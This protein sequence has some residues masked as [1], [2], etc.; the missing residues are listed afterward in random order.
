MKDE[1]ER[2]HERPPRFG[3]AWSFSRVRFGKGESE[4]ATSELIETAIERDRKYEVSC[5]NS[6]TII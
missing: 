5:K 4:F 6:G 2:R 1:K 3:S